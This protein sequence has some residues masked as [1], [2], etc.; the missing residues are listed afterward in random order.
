MCL[1]FDLL[2]PYSIG[3]IF[4]S[5]VVN[6]CDIVS[7]RGKVNTLETRNRIFTSMSSALNF[8]AP[9]SMGNI[10]LPWVICMCN[11]VTLGGKG[12]E[13]RNHISTLMSSALDLWPFDPKFDRK[14]LCPMDRWNVWYGEHSRAQKPYFHFYIQCAWPLILNLIGNIFLSWIHMCDMVTLDAKGNILEPGNHCICRQT[15]GWMD[16]MI[17]VYPPPCCRCVG[18]G[19]ICPPI[20]VLIKYHFL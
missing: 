13:H 18:G 14:H 5:R 4:L 16:S 20:K 7:L 11:M 2:T 8:W 15:D 12:L 10:F 19:C 9:N 6:M 17:P 1:T 3:N